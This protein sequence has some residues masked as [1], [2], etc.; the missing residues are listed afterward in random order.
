[1][2][3]VNGNAS[4]GMANSAGKNW[5][6]SLVGC[7]VMCGAR[8]ED[9]RSSTKCHEF[10]TAA[11]APIRYARG[12]NDE[13]SRTY[14]AE[15]NQPLLGLPL[16]EG[17]LWH[18]TTQDN[19]EPVT[20]SL[21]V[22]GIAFCMSNGMEASVSL[23]PFSLVRNCRFQVGECSKLKSFKISIIEQEVCCYFAVRSSCE[24]AAEEERS[25]WVLS[26]SQSIMLITS[27]LIPAVSIT[28][29]PLLHAPHTG[30][31]LLAGYLVY[32]DQQCISVVFAELSAHDAG[33][34]RFAVYE[35]HM[36]KR[37]VLDIKITDVAVCCDAVG[38]NSSC[39]DVDY[40][41][42]ASSTPSERK[43]WLRALSNVQVKIRN[44]APVPTF[45]E[46]EYFR[47][48]IRENIRAAQATA[49]PRVSGGPLLARYVR[50]FAKVQAADSG[51]G[52]DQ[53]GESRSPSKDARCV[54]NGVTPFPVSL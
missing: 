31:R 14:S 26:I 12:G 51:T 3:C 38:V 47:Q 39:F 13:T 40:H 46:L 23:S 6:E 20:F 48:A 28:C 49:A 53:G 34:A 9:A 33:K 37:L 21:Y 16:R 45:E 43:L 5:W 7:A 10:S 27:S 2:G 32:R 42:F 25:S 15:P 22:N 19:F 54:V 36:C 18:L 35:D 4:V 1:M 29:D 30:H 41:N 24:R 44:G 50:K 17:C 8:E 52:G 11:Q